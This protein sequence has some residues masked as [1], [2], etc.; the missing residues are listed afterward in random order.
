MNKLLSQYRE[1]VRQPLEHK[2]SRSVPRRCVRARADSP[3]ALRELQR[4]S[5]RRVQ[6]GGESDVRARKPAPAQRGGP[7]PLHFDETRARI[8]MCSL[9]RV[10]AISGPEDS[11]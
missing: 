1:P 11:K 5:L 6:L 8:T 9:A 10:A 2:T 4:P 3:S 7:G